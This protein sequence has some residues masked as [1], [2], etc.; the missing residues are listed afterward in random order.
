ML[1]ITI[2]LT[3]SDERESEIVRNCGMKY[4]NLVRYIQQS[5][6]DM[7]RKDKI[8]AI[9]SNVNV[10][11]CADTNPISFKQ[12]AEKASKKRKPRYRNKAS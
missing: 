3:V 7:F 1:K 9:V 11:V 6:V 4:Q 2:E 10:L 5:I 8:S 12:I